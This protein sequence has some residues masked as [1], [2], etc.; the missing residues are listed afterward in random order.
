MRRLISGVLAIAIVCL[1]IPTTVFSV[2]GEVVKYDTQKTNKVL[3]NSSVPNEHIYYSDLFYGYSSYLTQNT[4]LTTLERNTTDVTTRILNEY[5]TT[6]H[7]KGSTIFEGIGI[8]SDTTA[9]AKYISD[10]IGL[11][12]FQ[13]NN[14]LDKA[15]QKFAEAICNVNL[16]ASKEVGT[17]N[18]YI[19]NMKKY[20]DLAKKIDEIAIKSEADY[21]KLDRPELYKTFYDRAI[22]LLEEYCTELSPKLPTLK[23]ELFTVLSET[24]EIMGDLNNAVDFAKALAV[25]ITMQETQMELI[26]DV[27]KTQAP[28]STVY[29]GM[30]R[31]KNQL[32][33]GFISYFTTTYLTDKIFDK[34]IGYL[35]KL[36][37][38][39]IL[40][41]WLSYGSAIVSVVK[42]VNSIV[43]KGWLGYDY[44]E[45]TSAVMLTQY[46]S[47]L[48]NSVRNK[49][50]V[51]SSQFDNSEIQK[52]ETLYNA[53]IAMKSAAF[54]ECMNIAKHNTTYNSKYTDS[55]ADYFDTENAYKKYICEVKEYIS[56]IPLENRESVDLG[57]WTV[58]SKI[59][60]KNGADVIEDGIIYAVNNQS[61]IR[62]ILKSE[63]LLTICT[64]VKMN[65]LIVSKDNCIH[66][67]EDNL[68]LE[69]DTLSFN[70]VATLSISNGNVIVNTDV[71]LKGRDWYDYYNSL[72][73]VGGNLHV[74]GNL[75]I[76]ANGTVKVDNGSNC[77]VEKDI[78]IKPGT[79]NAFSY[80][81]AILD[82][83]TGI[84]HCKGNLNA[85]AGV[86]GYGG[87]DS[88]KGSLYMN[89]AESIVYIDGNFNI[90]GNSDSRTAGSVKFNYGKMFVRGNILC[91]SIYA[92]VWKEAL[93]ILNGLETQSLDTFPIYNVKI[94]NPSGIM[95]Q[96]DLNI[97]GTLNSNG[98]PIEQNNYKIELYTD[99]KI[100]GNNHL[101]RIS[102]NS[103]YMLSSN[104]T[105]ES[106][107]INNATLT[108]PEEFAL[109]VLGDL[110]IRYK[111][112]VINYGNL[113]IGGNLNI[114][115]KEVSG[116]ADTNFFNYN[117][118]SVCGDIIGGFYSYIY[119]EK[120]HS[121]LS[122]K[123][124]IDLTS[125]SC[126]KATAGTTILYGDNGQSITNYNCPTFIIKNS[127]E[128]GVVFNSAIS[129]SV[130]FDHQSNNF[131]LYNNGSGSLFV[132]YDG[133]GLK[134]NED[135]YPTLA[136]HPGLN[137]SS[138]YLVVHNNC[139]LNYN[140]NKYQVDN[141]GYSNPYVVFKLGDRTVKVDNYTLSEDGESY[142][143]TFD[144]I[145]PDQ[146]NDTISATLHAEFNGV[147]YASETKEYS[148]AQYCYNLLGK[149]SGDE[150][151]KLRTLLVDLLNYGSASQIY[152]RHNAESL[153]NTKLT[154]EQK[155]WG[156]SGQP[157]LKTVKNTAYKTIDNPS[158]TWKS[159]GLNLNK[160]VTMRFKIDADNIDGLSIG[161][162][163]ASGNRWTIGANSL[164]KTDGGYEFLFGRLGAGQ[165]SEPVYLT[166]YKG[167]TAVSDTICYSIESYAYAKQNDTDTAFG[168]L[169]ST[170]M[171]YGNSARAYAY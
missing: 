31:L 72:Y 4:Y 62:L 19:E 37:T 81:P 119:M 167:D 118:T 165:M 140:I 136:V 56:L 95:L 153:A 75:L 25:S 137:F 16:S 133:D 116:Y 43:F 123:G 18:K 36:T 86:S 48:Y 60:V 160:S 24:T 92:V 79:S 52:F 28:S 144:N 2:S 22:A 30:I 80:E 120:D 1:L 33:N 149:Y 121:V 87:G 23:S 15:N 109:T 84:I 40:N 76:N 14:E 94:S 114:R 99:S 171:K 148:V 10:N 42:L 130:L 117:L 104:L 113:K 169:L 64:N 47:D 35:P 21:N 107:V 59:S 157:E 147:E 63:T 89:N 97:Y 74:K 170:M 159:A 129:P 11:S 50:N 73:L 124:N 49:A 131:T 46:A 152:T 69:I 17:D 71:C 106:L 57:D 12:D 20:L 127:S 8:A 83:Y 142:V 9:V 61:N 150:D 32:S 45:Y 44:S 126:C 141:N 105:C 163:T 93:L 154:E 88:P 128:S 103:S 143:F 125:I 146:M 115:Q 55:V 6:G 5:I 164:Y 132:D 38:K 102:V 139:S 58:D 111:S 34:V 66:F 54:E 122:V 110:N 51:F 41:G 151:A 161:V 91:N 26:Q 108:I 166:V 85:L 77:T 90:N 134:D 13:F 155:S 100:I 168:N 156:T 135:P 3:T 96:S 53:Y 101:N 70:N 138:A 98:N 65:G 68:C 145:T 29:K 162:E 78:T 82:L 112:S 39:T 27:I 158:V 67:N 7:F